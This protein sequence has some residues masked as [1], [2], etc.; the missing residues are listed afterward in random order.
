MEISAPRSFKVIHVGLDFFKYFLHKMPQKECLMVN[1]ALRPLRILISITQ[2]IFVPS[3]TLFTESA[4]FGQI[5]ESAAK[6]GY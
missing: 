6:T 4:Q 3:F 1:H 2:S 5:P